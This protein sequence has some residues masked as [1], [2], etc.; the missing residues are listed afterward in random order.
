MKPPIG[1]CL[2]RK[3]IPGTTDAP[4]RPGMGGFVIMGAVGGQGYVTW[5]ELQ[6]N[7][8]M[9]TN[10]QLTGNNKIDQAEADVV[11]WNSNSGKYAGLNPGLVQ[12]TVKLRMMT[13]IRAP[14]W[15]Q[16][17]GGASW[18]ASDKGTG[19]S[20]QCGRFWTPP[21]GAASTLLL[22]A[23]A[24]KYD[25]HP[26]ISEVVWGRCMTVFDEPMLR[27]ILTPGQN[28]LMMSLGYYAED[29]GTQ[30]Q[31]FDGV[32]NGTV[33]LTSATANFVAGDVGSIIIGPGIPQGT[34]IASRT[35][36]SLTTSVV[37]SHAATKS[38]SGQTVTIMGTGTVSDQSQQLDDI[39]ILGQYFTNTRISY[40][41]NPYQVLQA[42]G[43]TPND[44]AFTNIAIRHG[45]ACWGAQFAPANNSLGNQYLPPSTGDYQTM[46]QVM[47]QEAQKHGSVC[48]IQTGVIGKCP[49][50]PAVIA[51]AGTSVWAGNVELPSGFTAQITTAAALATLGNALP[52]LAATTSPGTITPVDSEWFAVGVGTGAPSLALPA[53]SVTAG[54]DVLLATI[55]S[56]PTD[57]T[58]NTPTDSK[59]NTWV[60]CATVP[61]PAANETTQLWRSTIAVGKDGSI[62]ITVTPSTNGG[63][64]AAAQEFNG[65]DPATAHGVGH[66]IQF[67]GNPVAC[68]SIAAAAAGDLAFG[69]VAYHNGA[70]TISAGPS[71][72]PSNSPTSGAFHQIVTG[73]N[74]A[75]LQTIWQSVG[76]AVAQ[77]VDATLSGGANGDAMVVCF[78]AVGTAAVPGVP[79]G[80]TAHGAAASASFAWTAAAANGSAI[81]DYTVQQRTTAGPGSWST[82]ARTPSSPSTATSVTVTGLT[83]GTS[84]DF[85][86]RA[87]NGQGNGAYSGFVSATPAASPA[88]PAAPA[89][90]VP[91]TVGDGEINWDWDPPDPGTQP[92]DEYEITE[93]VV[94]GS[95]LT[96]VLINDGPPPTSA[97]DDT[98][99]TNGVAYTAT[100]RAH[101]SVGWGSMSGPSGQYMP[102]APPALITS[103]PPPAPTNSLAHPRISARWAAV[104]EGTGH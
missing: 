44:V 15:A 4:L 72:S 14:V 13:G 47:G 35:I 80:L 93:T 77:E 98:A 74:V 69:I 58:A 57:S 48:S 34:V 79:S 27:Q 26:L 71:F 55:S 42:N 38:A 3:G 40:T 99:L 39:S 10:G 97:Y 22:Q 20:G 85:Q 67:T 64:I 65:L 88:T 23:L 54:N 100:V 101:N 31:V 29:K 73:I 11:L 2:E 37:M 32:L 8:T 96:P 7:Q 104:L 19:Q 59:G 43:S 91:T 25:S 36:G 1:G 28:T 16:N 70:V 56:S 87:I 86:V 84:Y 103:S 53:Q 45:F 83:N 33:T 49:N 46:Y 62:V 95:S 90:P 78:H 76:S 66:M 82:S 51:Y 68:N 61:N 21:Y 41:F 75:A 102:S 6:A 81:T 60:L 12:E 89:A 63:I 9:N 30:R 50:L 18:L 5:N 52:N 24:A 17:L 94:G 92:I